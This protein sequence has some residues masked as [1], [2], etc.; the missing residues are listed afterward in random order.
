MVL[1]AFNWAIGGKEMISYVLH[2]RESPPST[3]TILIGFPMVMDLEILLL[4]ERIY[5]LAIAQYR[6]L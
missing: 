3:L 4:K 2:C 1:L 5:L 6:N